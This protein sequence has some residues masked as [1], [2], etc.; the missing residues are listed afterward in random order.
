MFGRILLVLLAS[1]LIGSIPVGYLIVRIFK[2]V[3]VR[4]V[5]SGRVG[6]TNTVRAA[7]PFAGVA[8]ALLDFG[9]GILAAY[10]A[11][12]LVPSSVWVKV[13]AVILAV[14]GQIFSVFLIEKTS[15]GKLIFRG[16]AGG[17]TT[18]GGAMALWPVSLIIILP[19]I[20]IVYFGIGYASLTTISIAF[21]SLVVFGY[22]AATGMSPWQYLIYGLV[23]LAMVII[24]LRPNLERLKNGTERVVGLRAL[25]QK[26]DQIKGSIIK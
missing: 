5:G 19:L 9:K 8:T 22:N 16:G 15:L 2:G 14:V 25:L 3:D 10:F 18:L 21:F 23:T 11:Y 7:G 26:K 13:S 6:T 1:Y 24:T 12:L 4:A 20:L 17:A